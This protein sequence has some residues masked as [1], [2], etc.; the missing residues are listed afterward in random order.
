MIS[1]YRQLIAS[2]HR[3]GIRVIGTTNPPFENAF[4]VL[5]ETGP[6]VT[7][8]TPEKE[9]VREKVND[10]IRNSVEFDAVIDFDEVLRD[11]SHPARLLPA[12]DSGDHLHPNDAGCI[13]EGNAVPLALFEGH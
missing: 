5:S 9:I 1:G 10:W 6:P 7:F 3:K 8:Y 13:A 2:A 11:P 12:Y 4:L